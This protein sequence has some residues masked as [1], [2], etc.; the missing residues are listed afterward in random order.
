MLASGRSFSAGEYGKW[1]G[2]FYELYHR[3]A[4]IGSDRVR[5]LAEQ[6]LGLFQM[7]E[8]ERLRL[9]GE[10]FADDLAAAFQRYEVRLEEARVELIAAMRRDVAPFGTE[11]V[12]R[13]ARVVRD[14]G[15]VSEAAAITAQALSRVVAA[16]QKKVS[17]DLAPVWDVDGS[18]TVHDSCGDVG[19]D[20]MLIVIKDELEFPSMAFSHS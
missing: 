19:V 9:P 20:S 6:L 10:R 15:I 4:L 14:V 18:L 11:S 12:D 3:V 8:S 5:T 13:A 16:V 7:I 2:D 17:R 1:S